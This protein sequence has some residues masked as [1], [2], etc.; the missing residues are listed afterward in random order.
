MK[1]YFSTVRRTGEMSDAGEYVHVDWEAKKVLSHA[2]VA[3]TDPTY[4]DPNPRGGK[5]GGRGI[6]LS[7]D[8]VLAACADRI[9]IFDR[10]MNPQGSVTNGLL[11]DVHEVHQSEPGRLW[12]SSTGIDAA[13]EVDLQSG[14]IVREFWPREDPRLQ[15]QLGLVPLDLDKSKDQRNRSEPR[16]ESHL[17]LNAVAMWNGELHALFHSK[18]V[19]VNLERGE[20]VV[21]HN[22][23]NLAHN[24][25]VVGDHVFV[26]ST[27]TRR[28]CEFDLSTGT[29]VKRL[30]LKEIKG[31]DELQMERRDVRDTF[32]KR[33]GARLTP[34]KSRAPAAWPRFAR[35]LQVVGDHLFV[36]ISPAT[37]L[38]IDWPSGALVEAFQYSDRVIEA[39]HGLWVETESSDPAPGDLRDG[40]PVWSGLGHGQSGANSGPES[41]EN[42]GQESGH[43]SGEESREM[44]EE[45]GKVGQPSSSRSSK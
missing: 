38:R 32:A 41:G 31:I 42:S 2:T 23:L 1:V 27:N 28:V 6:W 22:L 17:H 34:S 13:L 8:Q 29:L 35:G 36:G 25:V 37:V 26:C 43:T 44:S 15:S 10:N 20:V 33:L 45:D 21:N 18:A 16:D 9:N 11:S 12:V 39:V 14:Q 19:I 24:L 7:H 4:V 40:R 30:P 3:P 5:R